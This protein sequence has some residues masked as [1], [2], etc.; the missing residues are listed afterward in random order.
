MEKQVGIG[1]VGTGT[2]AQSHLQSLQMVPTGKAVVVFDV[3]AERAE[4][5]AQRFGIPNIA[6]SLDQVLDRDD[7]DGVIVATP[8]FAHAAPTIAALKA[9]KHVL[10]EKPFALD[11]GEAEDMVATAERT[12]MFLACCSARNRL[13]PQETRA[14]E[15]IEKGELGDVYHARS[16]FMRLRGRPGDHIMPGSDWFLDSARAGGGAMMDIAVYTIDSVLWMLGNPKVLSVSAQVRQF[17]EEKPPT[18]QDV[19]DHV[20]IMMQCEGGKSGIVECAW[21]SNIV[22]VDGLFIF[23]TKSGLMFEPLRQITVEHVDPSEVIKTPW[24]DPERQYRPLQ[25]QIFTSEFPQMRQMTNVTSEFARAIGEGR[26]PMTPGR[27]A[28]EVTKVIAAAYK[29]AKQGSSVTLV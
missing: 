1:I 7:V 8:P 18:K 3:I 2:I 9:G 11:V 14:H 20:V 4:R 29:S 28:L 16:T 17:T 25:K 15:M 22:G 5:T 13:S 19:E 26:Q 12:G 23:G 24:N 10:C 6:T 21:V 27:D